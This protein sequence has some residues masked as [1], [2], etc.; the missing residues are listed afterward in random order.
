MKRPFLMILLV[1]LLTLVAFAPRSV[2][3]EDEFTVTVT[4]DKTTVEVGQPIT[5]TWVP[6]G[7]T[8]PYSWGNNDNYWHIVEA[9]GNEFFISYRV[10]G[11]STTLIPLAGE[12]GQLHIRY[13]DY[14]GEVV[15]AVSEWFTIT[16]APLTEPFDCTITLDK[17]EVQ[18][19]E[20]IGVSWVYEGGTPPYRFWGHYVVGIDADGTEHETWFQPEDYGQNNEDT[21][22]NSVLAYPTIGETGYVRITAEDTAG[23]RLDKK[24]P[25]FFLKGNEEIKP[26]TCTIDLDKTTLNVGQSI[27][28]TWIISGGRAPYSII[29][30]RSG[31]TL[32][33]ANGSYIWMPPGDGVGQASIMTPLAGE[34]GR[35]FLGLQDADGREGFFRT[36]P[37][38]I[39]GAAIAD[40]LTGYVS[41][42]RTSVQEGGTFTATAHI[43]GGTPPYTIRLIHQ[44]YLEGGAVSSNPD[45]VVL[46][47]SHT[48]LVKENDGASVGTFVSASVNDAVGRSDSFSS[49]SIPITE[50]AL[51]G[52]TNGDAN[53]DDK[54]D[55]ADAQTLVSFILYQTQPASPA[56]ADANG[57][58]RVDIAD[59]LLVYDKIQN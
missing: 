28:A 42:D 15:E 56:S 25:V 16:G 29:P 34:S 35:F 6:S 18:S 49:P 43:S 1:L 26:L 12:K 58:G 19:G 22:R 46:A 23:R 54:V 48:F 37:F 27:T 17:S 40:K 45:D 13:S 51:P 8:P 36:D 30:Y 41:L 57:D 20:A 2:I 7:G 9:S 50:D 33:E 14:N 3:A 38:T 4:L 47:E 10:I 44:T 24:S 11:D 21:G 39:T 52:S 55:I 53:G 31:W 32:T 5:A 59:L